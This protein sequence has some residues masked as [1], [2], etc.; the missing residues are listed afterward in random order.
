MKTHFF[1]SSWKHKC[2]HLFLI[3]FSQRG[4]NTSFLIN[5]N[6]PLTCTEDLRC[7]F[8]S[9]VFWRIFYTLPLDLLVFPLC[10]HWKS[11]EWKSWRPAD[12]H[13]RSGPTYRAAQHTRS[14]TH[15][16]DGQRHV[17]GS[18]Q[19]K[20]MHLIRL[21]NHKNKPKMLIVMHLKQKSMGLKIHTNKSIV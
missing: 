7:S 9:R 19:R 17:L 20:I 12:T 6:N 8:Y 2:V 18:A 13:D 3:S 1:L 10:L 11:R 21:S 16:R 15:T 14:R 5:C 4:K